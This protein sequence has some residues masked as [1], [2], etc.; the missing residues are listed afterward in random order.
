MSK[1]SK[2]VLSV[3]LEKQSVSCIKAYV[4]AEGVQ[5]KGEGSKSAHILKLAQLAQDK[6]GDKEEELFGLLC[7]HAEK[8]LKEE[9]SEDV[10]KLTPIAKLSPGWPVDKSRILKAMKANLDLSKYSTVYE[11]LQ[12]T[13][14]AKRVPKT[15]DTKAKGADEGGAITAPKGAT[16]DA[17][18]KAYTR[19]NK[20]VK[21]IV[22]QRA[23]LISAVAGAIE[24]LC[25]EFD[26]MA[27]TGKTEDKEEKDETPAEEVA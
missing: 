7:R 11:V 21:A 5:R 22:I 4:K 16:G 20:T 25:D 13:P 1:T 23:D 8:V 27:K 19:L 2:M 26:S 18:L 14:E 17:L 3:D 12:A 24:H 10:K 15:A 9:K 6:G